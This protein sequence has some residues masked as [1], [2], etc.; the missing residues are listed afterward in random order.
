MP[1]HNSCCV[2]SCVKILSK[3]YR[4]AAFSKRFDDGGGMPSDAVIGIVVVTEDSRSRTCFFL[5]STVRHESAVRR[6]FTV[7]RTT[8]T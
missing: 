4:R 1:E 8:R 3:A 5:A 2:D 7:R 6:R